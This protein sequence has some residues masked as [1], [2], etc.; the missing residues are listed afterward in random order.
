MHGFRHHARRRPCLRELS[1]DGDLCPWALQRN[2]P[3]GLDGHLISS[4]LRVCR[5]HWR[6]W[7]PTGRRGVRACTAEALLTDDAALVIPGSVTS[8]GKARTG[9]R[10]R[11]T[12]GSARG[13][14]CRRPLTGVSRYEDAWAVSEKQ[15]GPLRRARCCGLPRQRAPARMWHLPGVLRSFQPRGDVYATLSASRSP[16]TDRH[17]VVGRH[18]PAWRTQCGRPQYMRM[19]PV[20]PVQTLTAGDRSHG[21]G[22]CCIHHRARLPLRR[23]LRCPVASWSMR[24]GAG[25][26]QGGPQGCQHIRL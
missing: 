10:L 13:C 11:A 1:R 22:A 7:Q 12:G 25:T 3:G 17:K 18:L 16:G 5:L 8:T 6:T 26:L 2:S 20:L 23:N 15:T 14:A 21:H 19:H 24:N 4:P 9:C